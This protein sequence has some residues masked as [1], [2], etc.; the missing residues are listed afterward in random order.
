M[1]KQLKK[2]LKIKKFCCGSFGEQLIYFDVN[3]SDFI[4]IKLIGFK[5]NLTKYN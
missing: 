4:G 1:E 3:T 5:I 2:K